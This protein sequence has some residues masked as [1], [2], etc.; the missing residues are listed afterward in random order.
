MVWSKIELEAGDEVV[1]L[2]HYWQQQPLVI[3]LLRHSG[4]PLC[5]EQLLVAE[6]RL[7]EMKGDG[8]AV[9]GIMHASGAEAQALGEEMQLRFPVLGDPAGALYRELALPRGSWWQVTLGPLLRSPLVGLR[10]MREVRKPG[11]DVR[12][13]GGV[14]IFDRDGELRYR[15]CQRDSGDLLDEAALLAA[16]RQL[17]GA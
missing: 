9:L 17:P 2:S 1:A 8:F 6:E 11:R 15:F 5:R 4:C 7:D 10:R 12:Q 16:T 14:A 3:L 13:L